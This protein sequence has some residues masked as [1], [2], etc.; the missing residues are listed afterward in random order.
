MLL[1]ALACRGC[2]A[3]PTDTSQPLDDT[4]GGTVE[5]IADYDAEPN[6]SREQ[7]IALPYGGGGRST[8]GGE[9]PADWFVVHAAHD[10]EIRAW[11]LEGLVELSIESEGRDHYLQVTATEETEYALL[12]DFLPDPA[13]V[14]A[15]DDLVVGEE[16]Q[17]RGGGFGSRPDLLRVHVDGVVFPVLEAEEEVLTVLVP[18]GASSG[19]LQLVSGGHPAQA[20]SVDVQ[21]PE[22]VLSPL[23]GASVLASGPEGDFVPGS[24]VLQ[25]GPRV[26]ADDVE[27]ISKAHGGEVEGW[28][29]H[30]RLFQLAVPTQDYEELLALAAELAMEDG[31]ESASPVFAGED[32]EPGQWDSAPFYNL[33]PTRRYASHETSGLESA[34]RTVETFGGPT[35]EAVQVAFVDTGISDQAHWPAGCDPGFEPFPSSS[36]GGPGFRLFELDPQL[37]Y[38]QAPALQD[39]GDIPSTCQDAIDGHGTAC[40]GVLAA[41][42]PRDEVPS[43]ANGAL[44]GFARA[45]RDP[46]FN[47]RVDVYST[48]LAGGTSLTIPQMLATLAQV[49][50]LGVIGVNWGLP[51]N[52]SVNPFE[53]RTDNVFLV[54]AHNRNSDVGTDWPARKTTHAHTLAI[55]AADPV[56][57]TRKDYSN[58]GIGVEMAAST[59]IWGIYGGPNGFTAVGGTS[60]ATPFTTAAAAF[61]RWLAPDLQASSVAALLVE[62]GA[63]VS[64]DS[65]WQ[66]PTMRRLHWARLATS[67]PIVSAMDLEV[68]PLLLVGDRADSSITALPLDES[69]GLPA[70]P[71]TRAPAGCLDPVDIQVSPDGA[72]AAVVCSGTDS[73][74]ILS[75]HSLEVIAEVELEEIVG[76]DFLSPDIGIHNRSW[77]SLT[78]MLY[79]PGVADGHTTVSMI[80]VYRG[81]LLG[82]R[83]ITEVDGTVPWGIAPISHTQDWVALL[84]SQ[85]DAGHLVNLYADPHGRSWEG[86]TLSA[87]AFG[88]YYPAEYPTGLALSPDGETLAVSFSG[89]FSDTELVDVPVSALSATVEGGK[90]YFMRSEGL[91]LERPY[92]VAWAPDVGL[93]G[94]QT[95]FV[96][97]WADESLVRLEKLGD[98]YPEG[99]E[100]TGTWET[101]TGGNPERVHVLQNGRAVYM[102]SWKGSVGMAQL[103]VDQ[104]FAGR[105]F[106]DTIGGF[107]QPVGV[108]V[109][110]LVSIVHPRHDASI[111][112]QLEAVFLLR[113]GSAA[114]VDCVISKWDG[115][116]I[117]RHALGALPAGY[118]SCPAFYLND[119]QGVRVKVEVSESH[120]TEAGLFAPLYEAEVWTWPI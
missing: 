109:T 45:G 72:R 55:G 32:T 90:G 14:D 76:N 63:D 104:S 17:L 79:V 6:D 42:G 38:G 99:W 53:H 66:R 81:E 85:G 33:S 50:D 21:A 47:A 30:A 40:V 103:P 71:G 102:S 95:L 1:L 82:T 100:V 86:G 112:G 94:I 61:V 26:T 105:S 16:A 119:E 3:D 98:G 39:L 24:L 37:Q 111:G 75:L 120:Q 116:E 4:G 13:W 43:K 93:D 41:L 36:N 12:V 22:Y 7:A 19:S 65:S 96:P 115:T 34:W 77:M 89:K 58:F 106:D 118:H 56:T 48:L 91:V 67:P 46:P 29:P 11:V 60:A 44:A 23:P 52:T 78:G 114:S 84:T 59:D 18:Y 87:S 5:G 49:P 92:D 20:V 108:M 64:F 62:T 117:T 113:S 88:D 80:D 107:D 110:P 8:V 9:D 51:G 101:S 57:D 69:T 68:Q 70:G 54:A 10:G 2:D 28:S 73:V 27:A 31:V 15:V 97:S 74:A 35:R 83:V 25:V